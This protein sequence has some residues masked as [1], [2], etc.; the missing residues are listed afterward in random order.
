MLGD[1]EVGGLRVGRLRGTIPTLFQKWKWRWLGEGDGFWTKVVA[2]IHRG[3]V[4]E[5][6]FIK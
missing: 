5:R 6:T 3:G 2:S 1:S 4:C